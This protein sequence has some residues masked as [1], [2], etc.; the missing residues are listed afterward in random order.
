MD[1]LDQ[2][3]EA[4]RLAL[5]KARA[6]LVELEVELRALE[7]AAAL[8]PPRAG[9]NQRAAPPSAHVQ[10]RSGRGGR[11]PGAISKPWRRLLMKLRELYPEGALPE[12][13]AS[14][15]PAIG[16]PNLR[17]RDARLQAEKYLERG[18]VEQVG[19]RYKV[20]DLAWG[21]FRESGLFASDTSESTEAADDPASQRK[22]LSNGQI[23]EGLSV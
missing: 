12:E 8:R 13:I 18:F 4:K 20:T 14:F 7:R 21:R 10:R 23:A 1:A 19:D 15:G 5:R 3:I 2:E 6:Q 16:L 17:P 9:V 22:L 11:V